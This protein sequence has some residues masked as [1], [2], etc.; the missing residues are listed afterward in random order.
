MAMFDETYPNSLESTHCGAHV[1]QVDM[2]LTSDNMSLGSSRALG[3]QPD[4]SWRWNCCNC[5]GGGNQSYIYNVNCI[6]CGHKRSESCCDIYI[7]K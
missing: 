4:A 2:S 5:S 7:S 3:G 1:Y 6:E